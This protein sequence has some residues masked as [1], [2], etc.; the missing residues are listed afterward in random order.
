M[1][2]YSHIRYVMHF[3]MIAFQFFAWWL[4]LQTGK[5]SEFRDIAMRLSKVLFVE[6]AIT[7]LLCSLFVFV[8]SLPLAFFN[9]YWLEHQFGLSQQSLIDWSGD[10]AKGFLVSYV[11]ETIWLFAFFY[12]VRRFPVLWPLMLGLL[13]VPLI[14]FLVYIAP[15]VISPVF[16]KFVPMA[17]CPLKIKIQSLLEKA[18]V[19]DAPI[20]VVDRSQQTKKLN[21]YVDGIGNSARVVLWD[22]LIQ[23]MPENQILAVVAHELGHYK[24]GHVYW[25]VAIVLLVN[26]FCVGINFAV[27]EQF[28]AILPGRWNISGLS[29]L[30]LIPVLFL[31]TAVGGF[32]AEPI[33]NG[34]SRFIEHQ[35]DEYALALNSDRHALAEAF[36]TLSEK[37]LSEPDP[38]PAIEFWL[39]SHPSL[40][41]RIDFALHG[42]AQFGNLRSPPP[43]SD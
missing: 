25:T 12:L 17:D 19:H 24:L 20:F 14:L 34:I 37:N 36:V 38:A 22:N 16:N 40:K 8:L 21:A 7:V 30:A 32:V 31:V 5:A 26:A 2:T 6:V 33:S 9:G 29:D 27:A 1:I 42:T 15:I 35:A 23:K 18:D 28:V 13:N 41:R 43:V 11:I 39:F 10:R 4:V 3:V